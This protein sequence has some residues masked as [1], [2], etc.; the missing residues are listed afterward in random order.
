MQQTFCLHQLF[1][2][3][4]KLGLKIVVAPSSF[5]KLQQFFLSYDCTKKLHRITT[6]F[7][8]KTIF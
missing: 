6:I 8:I 1:I 4:L 7:W 5:T 2:Y 3:F